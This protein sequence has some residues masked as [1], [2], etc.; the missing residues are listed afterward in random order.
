M[1]QMPRPAG[2]IPFDDSIADVGEAGVDA[3]DFH[4]FMRAFTR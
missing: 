1:R 4:N 3:H 2:V